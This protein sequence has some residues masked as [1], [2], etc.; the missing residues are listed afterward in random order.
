ML[1]NFVSYL[2]MMII[3]SNYLVEVHQV[4][5]CVILFSKRNLHKEWGGGGTCRQDC[6]KTNFLITN[7][8]IKMTRLE[9]NRY[10]IPKRDKE[11][12]SNYF[13]SKIFLANI[14]FMV[15]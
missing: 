8:N 10:L 9:K 3:Y 6:G 4:L 14:P 7:K 2:S 12:K 5:H 15:N 1:E 11:R 13:C